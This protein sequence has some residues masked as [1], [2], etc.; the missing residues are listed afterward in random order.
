VCHVIRR[1]NLPSVFSPIVCLL[2]NFWY[3][4]L[5]ISS[6]LL[7]LAIRNKCWAAHRLAKGGLAHLSNVC[8]VIR[9]RNLLNMSSPL[10]C[11]LVNF[12]YNLLAQLG[13][14]R[15][16]PRRNELSFA[17]WWRKANW[18]I[19]KAKRKG[20]HSVRILGAWTCGF[21]AISAWSVAPAL[22]SLMLSTTSR[23]RWDPGAWKASAFKVGLR[24]GYRTSLISPGWRSFFF[25]FIRAFFDSWCTAT[26][27]CLIVIVEMRRL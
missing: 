16:A 11:L 18:R 5:N 1:R 15:V 6:S 27:P 12:W 4:L 23:R 26:H 20:F 19:G 10:V 13:L 7:W 22:L 24:L 17:D 8:H 2:I 9:R 25:C 21:E 3:N 14:D